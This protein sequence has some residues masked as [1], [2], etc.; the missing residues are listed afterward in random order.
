MSADECRK[1]SITSGLSVGHECGQEEVRCEEVV[2]NAV[3]CGKE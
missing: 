3:E 2:V 1:K